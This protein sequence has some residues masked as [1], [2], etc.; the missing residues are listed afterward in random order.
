MSKKKLLLV[1]GL[2][3]AGVVLLYPRREQIRQGAGEWLRV[4]KGTVE[5]WVFIKWGPEA[6]TQELEEISEDHPE[7][8]ASLSRFNLEYG[9]VG[10]EA[11]Y[12]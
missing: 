6:L 3:S 2:A 5:G 12:N 9:K 4:A 7:I 1:A 11:S 8:A 10:D